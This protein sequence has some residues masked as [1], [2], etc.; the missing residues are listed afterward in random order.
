MANPPFPPC[1]LS[2]HMHHHLMKMLGLCICLWVIRL[3]MDLLDPVLFTYFSD[4]LIF[5]FSTLVRI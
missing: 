2:Y 4:Y 1:P 3:R 5:K